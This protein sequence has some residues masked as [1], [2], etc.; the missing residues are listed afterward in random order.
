R[1]PHRAARAAGEEP[2]GV[3][4]ARAPRD[5][6]S[7]RDRARGFVTARRAARRGAQ[8]RPRRSVRA[9]GD[10]G[11]G[12]RRAGPAIALGLACA[13]LVSAP[14]AAQEQKAQAVGV[15][16]VTKEDPS[17]RDSALRAAV[18]TAVADAA[19]A[20]LPANFVPPAPPP[21]ADAAEREPNAWLAER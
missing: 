20:M 12:M 8:A 19:A 3:R 2:G 6:G 1:S 16:P 21:A 15:A 10:G 18:R 11:A 5:P 14:L 17:P 13:A 9:R 4:G 7:E